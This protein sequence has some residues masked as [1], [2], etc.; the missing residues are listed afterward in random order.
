MTSFYGRGGANGGNGTQ[1][2][3]ELVNKPVTNL[4]SV[5]PINLSALTVGLYNIKGNFIYSAEDSEVKAFTS[6]TFVEILTDS[7]SGDKIATFDVYQNGKHLTYS[8]DFLADGSYKVDAY[9]YEI[10]SATGG[11]TEELPEVGDNTKIYVTQE[12]LYV[13]NEDTQDYVQLG[14]GSGSSEGETWD[15]M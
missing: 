6:P 2:Y 1:N 12:G 8:V 7:I 4:V 14:T 10:I 9:T 11:S 5:T 13:W 3:N 15:E